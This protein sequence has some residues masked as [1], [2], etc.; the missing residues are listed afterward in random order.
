MEHAFG[1]V[2][3]LILKTAVEPQWAWV[4]AATPESLNG[5]S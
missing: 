5:D 2:I 4:D 1:Y 3:P